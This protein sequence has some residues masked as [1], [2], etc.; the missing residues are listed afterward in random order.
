MAKH[1]DLNKLRLEANEN[2]FVLATFGGDNHTVLIVGDF[3]APEVI[4]AHKL[5]GSLVDFYESQPEVKVV[6]R[7]GIIDPTAENGGYVLE[8]RFLLTPGVNWFELDH[9]QFNGV[10]CG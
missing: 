5:T 3:N 4:T 1:Y 10:Y 7:L 2:G 6:E 8:A 9:S